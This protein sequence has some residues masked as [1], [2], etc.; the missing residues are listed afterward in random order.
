[1]AKRDQMAFKAT[2][3]ASR[4]SEGSAVKPLDYELSYPGKRPALEIL[5]G[6]RAKPQKRLSVT[7]S[8]EDDWRNRLYFGENLIVL[9]ALLDDPT[10]R[11][12]VRLVYIDPPFASGGVFESREGERAYEDIAY[13]ARYLEF[14]R[15]RLI[16]LRE[17][18]DPEGSIYLHLDDRMAFAVKVI[19]DEIFGPTNY[20]NWITRKKSNRKNSTRNQYGNI[21]DY[22]L[23]YTKSDNYLFNR[24]CESWTEEW[25]AREYQY[26]ED[27]TGR[28][29]KKVPVHAPGV[30]N[31]ETGK[32]WRGKSPP[33]GKHWQFPPGVL[34][35]MDA[36]GEIS[37]SPT[38]NPRRKLYFDLS[39]GVP[40]Q[41]I[42]L[43]Y[44]D[45]HN[46]MIEVTG[47]PTEK[48]LELLRRI[49]SASSDSGD[50]V[51]DCFAGSG[52]T[53]VAAEELGRRWIGI[54]SGVE[55]ISTTV[56]RLANGSERMG[57][58][59][60]GRKVKPKQFAL[61]DHPS[62]LRTNFDLFLA[63]QMPGVST[64]MLEAWRLLFPRAS[65]DVFP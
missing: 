13:G 65:A 34:D 20:R 15:E 9:R 39:E 57:D 41:D 54:D 56:N 64:D 38:G 46:Q 26:I 4:L 18:I 42:W 27:G 60:Q 50:L 55:S 1:M 44:R 10:V 47:Y 25:A 17:L 24:P 12:K 7:K 31:G 30:R 40:V 61:F 37:W 51:L 59:V 53:L 62:A 21:S 8:G 33:P 32:A 14:L 35:E 36:R 49:V 52:T 3:R 16:V 22:I 45:A 5:S 2:R 28:R 63:E 58:F 48:P 6:L 43:D 19:M 23:F 29:Y 11:G